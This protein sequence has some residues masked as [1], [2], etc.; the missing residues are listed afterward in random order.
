MENWLGSGCDPSKSALAV[1]KVGSRILF[2]DS[3][4]NTV[5]SRCIIHVIERESGHLLP[6]TDDRWA[7]ILK[8]AHIRKQTTRYEKSKYRAVIENLPS[9]K[10]VADGYHRRC[11]RAFTAIQGS[12]VTTAEDQEPCTS[13]DLRSSTRSPVTTTE[14]SCS[15]IFENKCLYC[16]KQL[17]TLKD[18]KKEGLGSVM[19]K[20]AEDKIREAATLLK[21]NTVLVKISGIDLI[22]KE[23]KFHHS[24]R[25]KQLA[26]AARVKTSEQK[27]SEQQTTE[28]KPITQIFDYVKSHVILESRPERLKSVFDRYHTICQIADEEST[29]GSCQYLG[30]LLKKQF[31]DELSISSPDAKRHGSIIHNRLL[32]YQSIKVVYDFQSSDEGQLITSALLM[33]KYLMSVKKKQP[34]TH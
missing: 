31:P 7:T 8:S 17:K 22:A 13:R 21:D 15:G 20:E 23:V 10:T 32:D 28:N 14:K 27:K 4:E 18:G 3:C 34:P 1:G 2:S 24:C 9:T 25:R 33:R 30:D 12:S 6:L 5:P 11:Y 16:S 19:T 29:I 26:A